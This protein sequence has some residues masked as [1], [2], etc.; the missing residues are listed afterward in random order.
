MSR[1]TT[2]ITD[3][4]GNFSTGAN[5]TGG[6][7]S[8]VVSYKGQ[9]CLPPVSTTTEENFATNTAGVIDTGKWE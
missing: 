3:T 9:I 2:G 6:N 4:G 7:F 5:D 1:C 8:A